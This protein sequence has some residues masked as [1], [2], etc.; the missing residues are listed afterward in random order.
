MPRG[1]GRSDPLSED[2]LVRRVLRPPTNALR[3]IHGAGII[4]R[5]VRPDNLFW[6][7]G[8][9]A[10]AVLGEGW[11]A[12]PASE[13]PV[14]FE[15]IGSGM[16]LPAARGPGK[17]ADDLYP[18]GATLAVLLSG[19]NPLAPRV[20]HAIIETHNGHGSVTTRPR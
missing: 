3:D 14:L 16:A 7:D 20:D 13:Q 1:D 6:R 17:P 5:G 2:A 11:V 4:H 10:E 19:D 8:G 12:P 15:T 18:L 9:G